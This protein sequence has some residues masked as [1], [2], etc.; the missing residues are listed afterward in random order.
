[1]DAE[2]GRMSAGGNSGAAVAAPR[3]L[4]RPRQVLI[5][6]SGWAALLTAAVAIWVAVEIGIAG[7]GWLPWLACA[8]P[9]AAAGALCLARRRAT[10]TAP[11]A[12]FAS[13]AV[14]GAYAVQI[15]D[16]R[17]GLVLAAAVLLLLCAAVAVVISAIVTAVMITISGGVWGG[18]SA[19]WPAAGLLF[20]ALSIPSPVYFSGSP[21]QTI[22]A[23]N[24]GGED[25]AAV[26]GLALLALPLV[27]A[28][29]ASARLATVIAVAWLPAATGELLGWYVFQFN[30]QHLDAWYYVSW[31]AWLAIAVLTLAKARSWQSGSR[32]QS[33]EAPRTDTGRS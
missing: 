7:R 21:I 6:A 24:T 12:V 16:G 20:A 11:A 18:R 25:A 33:P 27:V 8:L 1:M 31:I 15:P 22:F 28:G 2:A 3:E 5:T 14:A 29:L 17:H 23:G 9:A 19:V 26:C 10:S 32:T 4:V 13:C 30:F